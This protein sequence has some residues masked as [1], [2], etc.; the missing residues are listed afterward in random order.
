MELAADL[1][2]V[3]VI[4]SDCRCVVKRFLENVVQI[5]TVTVTVGYGDCLHFLLFTISIAFSFSE[6]CL[7]S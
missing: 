1:E 6:M 4:W 5:Y 2:Q 7:K 3:Q